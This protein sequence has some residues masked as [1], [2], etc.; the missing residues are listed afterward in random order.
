MKNH[1]L[2]DGRNQR[3]AAAL[4][5]ALILPIMVLLLALTLFFGRLF[6]HYTVIQN[7]AHDAAIILANATRLEIGT[8]KSDLS[9]VEAANLARFVVEEEIAGLYPGPI[10]P[11][12]EIICDGSACK[13]DTVPAQVRVLI[14]MKMFDVFLSSYTGDLGGIDGLWIRADVRVPYVG[15]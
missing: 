5:F 7:A 11:R 14:T 4:E 9:D 6:W 13:G 2:K 15:N 1:M 10:P 12:I 8:N 3:G